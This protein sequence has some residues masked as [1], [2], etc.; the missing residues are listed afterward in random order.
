MTNLRKYLAEFIGTFTLVFIGC[1]TAAITGGSLLITSLAFGIAIIMMAYTVGS[2]SGG[3]FNP[4]V[5]TGMLFTGKLSVVDFCGYVISQILGA[6][7]GAGIL[8]MF[9]SFWQP[10]KTSILGGIG[11]PA[12]LDGLGTN[13]FGDM[14]WYGA[15]IIEAV[16]TFLFVFIIIMVCN[17]KS[18]A[19]L[20]GIVIGF[21]L[22]A[23]HFIG[24]S[25]TG[26][27]VN[28][29][30][31]IGPA[32]FTGGQPLSQL[33][34]FIAAPLV[35]AVIAAGVSLIFNQKEIENA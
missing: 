1:G 22:A 3:H 24:I 34:V 2:V 17:N 23:I 25:F 5:S 28:P 9:F 26:T 8:K 30:R 32:L 29:A 19:N 31:S 7:A 18:F 12:N 4:A 10:E 11:L 13:A 35:G 6:I 14:P 20:A 16:L 15:F 21:S 33:W 27:S